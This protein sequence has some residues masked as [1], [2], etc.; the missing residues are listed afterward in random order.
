MWDF[1]IDKKQQFL[2]TCSHLGRLFVYNVLSTSVP[3]SSSSSAA[4]SANDLLQ[5]RGTILRKNNEK[6]VGMALKENIPV[7]LSTSDGTLAAAQE[8]YS[9]L[10]CQ[11]ADKEVEVIKIHEDKERARRR[12]RR[13]NRSNKKQKEKEAK[14]KESEKGQEDPA[15]AEEEGDDGESLIVGGREGTHQD[16]LPDEISS[17]FILKCTAKVVSVDVHP[18]KLEC[19]VTTQ[20][21][22]IE[23]Y[24]IQA[25]K[26]KKSRT[27]FSAEI[28]SLV[29]LPGHRTDIRALALSSDNALLA[30]A[31]RNEL[32]VWNVSTR[33]CLQT[34]STGFGLCCSF[35]PGDRLLSS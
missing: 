16:S 32:K 26:D 29:S 34:I 15:N 30:S 5:L 20:D 28:H 18:S 12:R 17:L 1:V 24:S 25:P 31:S 35:L 11:T 33:R 7:P 23:I 6:I 10:A 21:N 2:Y 27:S 13:L 8:T 4:S 19:C 9:L 14:L 3:P 22:K